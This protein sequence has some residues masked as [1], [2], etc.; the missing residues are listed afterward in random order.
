MLILLLGPAQAL[1]QAKELGPPALDIVASDA[2]STDVPGLNKPQAGL[3]TTTMRMGGKVYHLEVAATPEQSEKGLM[4][5][6]SLPPYQ[7]MLFP[8][9]PARP[10]KFW[11]KNTKIPLDMLFLSQGQV[12]FIQANAHPCLADP[13]TIYGPDTPVDMVVELSAGSVSKYKIS[14][15]THVA[16]DWPRMPKTT[17]LQAANRPGK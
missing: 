11:M 2:T 3:P 6:T 1:L 8:F 13:C 7:G 17:A 9:Q 10:V 16:I 12:T 5:R 14:L 15:G 4:F